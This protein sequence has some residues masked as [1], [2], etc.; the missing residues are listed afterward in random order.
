MSL[1]FELRK[2]MLRADELRKII[3]MEEQRLRE[4]HAMA[5]RIFIE[6][7]DEVSRTTDPTM[8]AA[9]LLKLQQKLRP[10][11]NEI[12]NEVSMLNRYMQELSAVEADI[13]RVRMEMERIRRRTRY[14][15]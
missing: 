1:E 9:I 3:A 12:Y 15:V 5:D 6:Y 8:R 11:R 10:I 7:M 4:K 2:L 14:P 13:A